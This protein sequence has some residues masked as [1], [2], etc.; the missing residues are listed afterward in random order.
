M[1]ALQ[2]KKSREKDGYQQDV[3]FHGRTVHSILGL[4]SV[5][6]ASPSIIFMPLFCMP[7]IFLTSCVSFSSMQ[8]TSVPVTY[9]TQYIALE[10]LFAGAAGALS[11]AGGGAASSLGDVPFTPS[12]VPDLPFCWAKTAV[13]INSNAIVAFFM[14]NSFFLLKSA[15]EG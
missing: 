8:L 4:V 6:L 9:D 5:N 11:C 14:L 2:K 15:F 7:Q 10:G 12:K 1:M 3:S 13:Q